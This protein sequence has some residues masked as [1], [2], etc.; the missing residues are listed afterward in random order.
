MGRLALSSQ[1]ARSASSTLVFPAPFGPTSTVKRPSGTVV[2]RCALKFWSRIEV[3]IVLLP[4]PIPSGGARSAGKASL[5][6]SPR[7][8]PARQADHLARE[9]P[10][11]A[12]Q[13][14]LD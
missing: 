5:A 14:E 10:G 7:T 12:R 3:I 9:R 1:T 6:G 4:Y 13:P 8:S 11:A 2:S